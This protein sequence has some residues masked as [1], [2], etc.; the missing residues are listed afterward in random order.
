MTQPVWKNRYVANTGES[1]KPLIRRDWVLIEEMWLNSLQ[2][3][4]G[5]DPQT[6]QIGPFSLHRHIHFSVFAY[7]ATAV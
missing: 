4:P 1:R 2:N 6:D 7:A 5:A 3:Y